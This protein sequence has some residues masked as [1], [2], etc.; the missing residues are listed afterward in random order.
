MQ[1]ETG[2][3]IFRVK[4]VK[5]GRQT[6]VVHVTLNQGTPG[7]E[8]EEVVGYIT[9][10]NLRTERGVSYDTDWQSHPEPP[11]VD[12][13][14]LDSDT[15]EHWG[16]RKVIPFQ[17]FRKAA[18]RARSWYPK[19]GQIKPSIVDQWV[20]LKDQG[21]AWTNE[22]LGFVVDNFPQIIE[23][24]HD[25][26]D[27][28]SVKF[29]KE[30]GHMEDFIA[31]KGAAKMWYPTLLLNLDIKKALPE[32]GVRFLYVRLQ[33][34]QIKN[35]RYDLEIVVKDPTGDLVALSHHMSDHIRDSSVTPAQA[36][37]N[38]YRYPCAAAP[39]IIRSNQKDAYFQS[40]LLTQLSAVIRSLYGAR[41]AH[42]WTN[43]TRT[44]TELLYLGLTTFVGNRT[45]G[46]EYC[47]IVQ[48]EDDTGR[49]PELTRRAGYILSS[50]L[51]P[52]V[53]GRFLPAL[54]RRLRAKLEVSMRKSHRRRASSPSRSKLPP[55]RIYQFQEYVSK[56][57]D[58]ITSPA[59]VY[60]LSLAVFYF[61]GAYYQISKRIFGLRYIFTRKLE[62]S[63]QRAGYEV[64]GILLVLQMIVQGYLHL[65]ETYTHAATINLPSN[66]AA[67]AGTSA[68]IDN[69]VEVAA[70]TT[71][72]APLLFEAP[73]G[74]DPVAQ[75][76]QI[77]KITHT[78][79]PQPHRHDLKDHEAMQW[80]DGK[81]QR[82]C[83]LCL[84]PLKDPSVTTCG[85]VFCW[86]CVADWL[87][88]QPM[89]PL[90]RQSA[91]VQHVLPLQG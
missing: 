28:Y 27:M 26:G 10:S 22:S 13:S 24:F 18:L 11:P 69:G 91:L 73:Q 60:A 87:R 48:V 58:T 80:I 5:L 20:C 36:S 19:A 30:H 59:P 14:K 66:N 46:E 47:D 56:H 75:Q 43:E 38:D 21:D 64:L 25:G 41:T 42:N 17:D 90:C 15:D 70:D 45:L 23:N 7:D 55:S 89:C 2:Q 49:L 34:K 62:P 68:A 37:I 61:S 9:Q 74:A 88:E 84:E 12:V 67:A 35:G 85:H 53:L 44:F 79:L 57:L 72:A 54:R 51:V 52:Y 50:V 33:A 31:R 76:E 6:S 82:K 8:R 16:E 78:P 29:E 4:D 81:Q 1:Y 63:E 86:Q 71:I 77:S 40:V 32:Q 3:A 65:H 83:T 39:D